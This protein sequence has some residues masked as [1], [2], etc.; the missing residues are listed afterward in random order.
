MQWTPPPLYLIDTSLVLTQKVVLHVIFH[1][2]NMA[3]TS[4]K[5]TDI[6]PKHVAEC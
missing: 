2:K 4:L 6:V 3:D 1:L 5:M